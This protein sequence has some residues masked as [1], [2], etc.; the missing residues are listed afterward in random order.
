MLLYAKIKGMSTFCLLYVKK[1]TISGFNSESI[2]ESVPL[3]V[4][5]CALDW[6]RIR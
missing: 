2:E 4:K 3:S 5:L 1:V 6:L